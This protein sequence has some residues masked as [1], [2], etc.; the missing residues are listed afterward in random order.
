VTRP[1]PTNA[2]TDETTGERWYPLTVNGVEYRLLS[3]TTAFKAIAKIGLDKW[4]CN[5]TATAAFDELPTVITASRRKPCGRTTHRC[6]DHDWQ[7]CQERG[8]GECKACVTDWLASRHKAHSNRRSD[9]GKRVHDVIEWWSLHD[10]IKPHDDDIAPYVAA[11]LAF[12]AEYGLRPE[13][14]I[15]CE[16]TCINIEDGYA[17][18]TDGALRFEAAASPA[19]AK[20]VARV[21]RAAGEYAHL[22]TSEAIRKAVVRDKRTVVLI[23][24]WKTREGE[25]ERYYS[26]HA[27]QLTGYRRC[28]I[29]RI[30]DTETDVEMPATDGAV[31]V[32]LRPDG[33]GVRL[34]VTD[35]ASYRAFLNALGLYLWLSECGGRA[36]GTNSFPLG[37]RDPAPAVDPVAATDVPDPF[38]LVAAA[39]DPGDI[40]IPF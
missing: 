22:K 11:F 23:V 36:M 19:A 26:E 39:T 30:K 16:A 1:D 18:T 12:V 4:M 34:A 32:Q 29:I 17:G 5:I 31:I 3:V 15:L 24:D 2:V 6:K 9:E 27:L 14:F 13:S 37:R 21:L 35:D 8:C 33:A 40:K 28:P 38:E 20:L 25:G 10:A 7:S